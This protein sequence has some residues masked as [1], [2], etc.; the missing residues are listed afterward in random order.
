VIEA[1]LIAEIEKAQGIVAQRLLS[2][3]NG[4]AFA[5]GKLVG[6]HTGLEEVKALLNDILSDQDARDRSP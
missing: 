6:I 5:Y 2:A 3:P 1:K 4:D